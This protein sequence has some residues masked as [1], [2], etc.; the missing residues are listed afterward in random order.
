MYAFVPYLS[1]SGRLHHCHA[2]SMLSYT[3]KYSR[4]AVGQTLQMQFPIWWHLQ[5]WNLI[6]LEIL[7]LC[8][9]QYL[10]IFFAGLNTFMTHSRTSNISSGCSFWCS[11]RGLFAVAVLHWCFHTCLRSGWSPIQPFACFPQLSA[12]FR[13]DLHGRIRD[14]RPVSQGK[15]TPTNSLVSLPR[16]II[17]FVVCL[18]NGQRESNMTCVDSPSSLHYL[19]LCLPTHTHTQS[20]YWPADH[21]E[22]LFMDVAMSVPY[23][24]SIIP[25]FLS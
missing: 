16:V 9:Q 12:L 23:R 6:T 15:M 11:W 17:G 1:S 21:N 4:S 22:S 14:G 3:I 8:Q 20:A 13:K 25:P 5:K 24:V 18:V 7:K 2:Y 19:V 10:L